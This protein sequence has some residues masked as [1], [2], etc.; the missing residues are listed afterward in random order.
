MHFKTS[1][2]LLGV[3]WARSADATYFVMDDEVVAD[4][5]KRGVLSGVVLCGLD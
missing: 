1:T 3:I 5:K 4:V 2:C